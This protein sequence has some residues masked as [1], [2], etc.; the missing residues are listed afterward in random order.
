VPQHDTFTDHDEK[1]IHILDSASAGPIPGTTQADLNT[2]NGAAINDLEQARAEIARQHALFK[3]AV[4][5]CERLKATATHVQAELKRFQADRQ[6]LKADLAQIRHSGQTSEAHASELT[7]ALAAA[8]QENADL[9]AQAHAEIN[10]LHERLGAHEQA[11]NERDA[12]LGHAI[13]NLTKARADLTSSVT[14]VSGLRSELQAHQHGLQSTGQQLNAAKAE[15]QGLV[16]HHQALTEEH[17]AT[18]QQRDEWKERA[19][20]LER[21]LMALDT[22]RDL[23][24][25]RERYKKLEQDHH[26]LGT[27]LADQSEEAEKNSSALKGIV[28]RQNA[29]LGAYHSELRRLRRARFA[30]RLVYALFF[31]GLLAL[32]YFA[33]KTFAPDQIT[34]LMQQL[35]Q[36]K[37]GF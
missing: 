23:L 32:A 31:L 6:Q 17:Q 34:G 25:L 30:V 28:E 19:E 1:E 4:E 21:D 37:S 22:G 36:F 5:E 8:Q 3:R 2:A 14:E 20:G 10:T 11:L 29:T 33:C 18:T 9:R 27:K 26:A 13:R 35:K 24:E 15:L 7:V 16:A 12:Q